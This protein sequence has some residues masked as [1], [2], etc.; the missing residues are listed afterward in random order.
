MRTVLL[1][2]AFG[3]A[4]P[5]DEALLDAFLAALPDWDAVATSADPGATRARH[6][7]D[8]VHPRDPVAVARALAR[9][10]GVVFAGGTIFKRL[11]PCTR[12]R[13]LGLLINAVALAAAAR[14]ARKPVALLGVG[15]GDL[16][17]G[18][19]RSL[20]RH[21]VGLAQLVILRDDESAAELAAAGV[22]P[23]FRVGADPAWTLVQDPPPRRRGDVVVVAL[24]HLAVDTPAG[25]AAALGD[26]AAAGYEIHLQPWQTDDGARD[27]DL[28]RDVAARLGGTARVVDAPATLGAACSDFGAA[29]AVVGLRFH[30]L[31]AAGAARTPFVAV[32]H[33][34]KLVAAARRFGQP[35][36]RP[37]RDLSRL[38]TAVADAVAG[39]PPSA[40]VAH[41]EA[42]AAEEGFRLLRLV[43][44]RGREGDLETITGLPLVPDP[45]R[46]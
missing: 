9:C 11:H 40:A 41:R 10:D 18:P 3:Q 25:L 28:A 37:G 43:L 20:A 6:R 31:V 39:P 46:P 44:S 17:G 35:A 33:E 4:N 2:G 15:A 27:L 32:T 7:C 30:S 21:L 22:A 38:G 8:A 1:A 24:S 13:P 12:R 14:A 29:R 42:A 19:A 34:P 23:P 45:W 36:L 26:V 16:H 5:G